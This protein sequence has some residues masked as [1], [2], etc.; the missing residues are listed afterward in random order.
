VLGTGTGAT[1][2]GVTQTVVDYLLC[3]FSSFLPAFSYQY[4][5]IF[6]YPLCSLGQEI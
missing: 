3:V 1:Q 6:K 4:T 2:G 5:G